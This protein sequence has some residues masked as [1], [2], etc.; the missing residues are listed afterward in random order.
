MVEISSASNAHYKLFHSL[1][2]SKG[3]KAEGQFILSGEKLIKELPSHFELVAEILGPQHQV[4]S[5]APKQYRLSGELFRELDSLGTHF[6]LLVLKTPLLETVEQNFISSGRALLVPL[7]DPS[8]LGALLRSAEAFGIEQILLTQESANPFLPKSIK[9]SA[10]SVLRLKLFKT[11]AFGK[12]CSERRDLLAL[13][14]DGEDIQQFSWPRNGI[15]AVGEEGPGLPTP[16]V[17]KKL[18]VRT[19]KVESLNA[20]V[21]ASL[22]LYTWSQRHNS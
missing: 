19:Q 12:W 20:T 9:A 3:I 4:V 7:G 1:L 6:N 16:F 15:L 8:N 10:G 14:M 17:G 2:T 5:A 22:A 13:D 11:C 18:F 21:A